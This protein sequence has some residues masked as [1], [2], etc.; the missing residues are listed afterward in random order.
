MSAPAIGQ[1]VH[2]HGSLTELHGPA[3]YIGVCRCRNA[4]CWGAELEIIRNGKVYELDHVRDE[5]YTI[6]GEDQA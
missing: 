3:F 4:E 2:Y 6:V 5:S 1:T